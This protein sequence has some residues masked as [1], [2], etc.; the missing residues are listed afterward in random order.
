MRSCWGRFARRATPSPWP[1]SGKARSDPPPAL[2]ER[3]LRA[4]ARGRSSPGVAPTRCC[5]CGRP[6]SA[7]FGIVLALSA[8]ASRLARRRRRLA[9][10]CR[11]A[12]RP[13]RSLGG[14]DRDRAAGGV[15]SMSCRRR[16]ATLLDVT[17]RQV[18]ALAGD[19]LPAC[20]RRRLGALPLRAR[21]CSRSTGRSTDPIPWTGRGGRACRHGPPRGHP[22]RDRGVGGGSRPGAGTRATVRPARAADPVRPVARPGGQ[23][24][25][26]GLLPRAATARPRD[27]TEAIE[28]QVERFAPGFREGSSAA[29]P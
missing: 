14:R 9:A 7:A 25:G 19:R 8:H 20:Y 2:P 29:R 26:L 22:R 11:C 16:G 21:A 4:S 24:H 27:M 5:R 28:A 13:L 17:P 3:A 18:L 12:R 10:A 1:A 15:A 6:P 23:A